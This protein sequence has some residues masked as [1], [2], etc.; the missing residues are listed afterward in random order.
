MGTNGTALDRR[1]PFHRRCGGT[2]TRNLFEVNEK[3]RT[4]CQN[5]NEYIGV[6]HTTLRL[7][8][9]YCALDDFVAR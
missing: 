1:L 3:E 5:A 9:W 4:R 6:M 7:G 2:D 8:E